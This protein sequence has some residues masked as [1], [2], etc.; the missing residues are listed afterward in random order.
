MGTE[1]PACCAIFSI[2]GIAHLV[3]FGRMFSANAV[4]FAILSVENQ[5]A[6]AEKTKACYN[7]A[8]IY[9]VTLFL[10]VVALVY[11]RRSEA[12]KN[13]AL[14]ARHRQEVEALLGGAETEV[15]GEREAPRCRPAAKEV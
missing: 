10:S 6:I 15:A 12:A 11:T 13:V 8:I 1:F 14:H 7:G 9:A 4:S 2:L 3:L 5:W